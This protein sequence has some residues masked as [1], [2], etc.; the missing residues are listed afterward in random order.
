MCDDASAHGKGRL[1]WLRFGLLCDAGF[2]F[3]G[4]HEEES[5]AVVL[6]PLYS[7]HASKLDSLRLACVDLN[8]APV[9]HLDDLAGHKVLL[10]VG[11]P[12]Q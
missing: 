6:P 10:D 4:R 5:G 1:D 3:N 12:L 11:R 2:V 8:A 9:H 7:Q